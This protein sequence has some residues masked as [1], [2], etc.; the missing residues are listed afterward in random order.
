MPDIKAHFADC[1]YV[2]EIE[3]IFKDLAAGEH[4]DRILH[5][6]SK[7]GQRLSGAHRHQLSDLAYAELAR[8]K[9][10]DTGNRLVKGK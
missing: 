8:R 7:L 1:P 3:A 4:R 6:V 5:S 10:S 9:P 2:M